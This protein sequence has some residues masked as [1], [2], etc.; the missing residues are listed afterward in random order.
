MIDKL[1]EEY[2]DFHDALILNF[3]YKTNIDLSNGFEQG[4]E[5]IILIISCFNLKKDFIRQ[6][7]KISFKEVNDFR[8]KRYPGMV[9]NLLIK[10]ENDYY[11]FDFDPTILT[12]DDN[13]KF[14]LE[15]NSESLLSIK[16][17]NL[18]FEV[19]D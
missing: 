5:E 4:I 7:L 10:K 11:I 15:R 1:I 9:M 18:S 13:G 6:T 14:I 17:K 3:E 12:V 19:I 8:I 2:E 16:F